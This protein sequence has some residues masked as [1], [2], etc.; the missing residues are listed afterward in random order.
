MVV[1]VKE[2]VLFDGIKCES[3]RSAKAK[4]KAFFD[5]SDVM[6]DRSLWKNVDW[7]ESEIEVF[8]KLR[9]AMGIAPKTS[10]RGL[11]TE[12]AAAHIGTIEKEVMRGTEK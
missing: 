5:L 4:H 11:N 3:K 2:K 10:K 9:K 6:K 8:E 7:I 12:G 1:S